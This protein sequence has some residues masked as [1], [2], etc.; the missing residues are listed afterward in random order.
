M[1]FYVIFNRFSQSKRSQ[2]MVQNYFVFFFETTAF[3]CDS[4]H[5]RSSKSKVQLMPHIYINCNIQSRFIKRSC[6]RS[7]TE[8]SEYNIM[9]LMLG[10]FVSRYV[11]LAFVQLGNVI[12]LAFHEAIANTAKKSRQYTISWDMRHYLCL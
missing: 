11:R 1:C 5:S 4:T 10:I 12:F 3:N 9:S 8:I 6:A 2:P 7:S